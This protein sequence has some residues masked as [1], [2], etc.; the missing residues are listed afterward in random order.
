MNRFDAPAWTFTIL[1]SRKLQRVPHFIWSMPSSPRS[2]ARAPSSCSPSP[3]VFPSPR[4]PLP[5]ATCTHKRK[6]RSHERNTTQKRRQTCIWKSV[7]WLID[8]TIARRRCCRCW[9]DFSRQIDGFKRNALCSPAHSLYM[10][11]VAPEFL[12]RLP[13]TTLSCVSDW[14]GWLQGLTVCTY[15]SWRGGGGGRDRQ[16]Q[17]CKDDTK[18]QKKCTLFG[19]SLQNR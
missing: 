2:M 13:P 9:R 18:R 14:L 11:S 12:S 1:L 8:I 4:F 6:E 5:G 17:S 3:G 15:S 16:M 7:I 10:F 19:A